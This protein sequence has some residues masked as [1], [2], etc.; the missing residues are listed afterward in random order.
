MSNITKFVPPKPTND[1]LTRLIRERCKDTGNI[2]WSNHAREQME[3]RGIFVQDVL[4]VLRIGI[5]T[6]PPKL[7]DEGEWEVKLDFRRRGEREQGVV[8][9]VCDGSNELGI[10]TVMWNDEP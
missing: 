4:R 9:V 7:S 5:I 8:T 1:Q 10:I 3:E 6:N 2:W